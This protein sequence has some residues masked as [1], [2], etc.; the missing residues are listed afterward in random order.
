M[1]EGR[2]YEGLDVVKKFIIACKKLF[3][4]NSYHVIEGEINIM[5]DDI[6]PKL[7]SDN[8]LK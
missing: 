8:L 6:I 2:E 3:R 1:V 7:S 4:K 5:C